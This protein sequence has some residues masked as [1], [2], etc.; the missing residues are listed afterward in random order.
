[1]AT[2]ANDPLWQTL[3]P[4]I[5][6]QEDLKKAEEQLHKQEQKLQRQRTNLETKFK[7]QSGRQATLAFWTPLIN[8]FARIHYSEEQ[9]EQATAEG[10]KLRLLV[11]TLKTWQGLVALWLLSL[12][13]VVGPVLPGTIQALWITDGSTQILHLCR[14][15]ERKG[16]ETKRKQDQWIF[17]PTPKR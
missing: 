8:A 10:K 7:R 16:R 3:N 13:V 11:D 14:R 9:V 17:L 15:D 2:E 1:A 4:G 5:Q 12:L 6:A